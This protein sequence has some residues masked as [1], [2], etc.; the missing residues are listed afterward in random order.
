MVD[1]VWND[2]VFREIA[3]SG[4]MQAALGKAAQA[5]ADGANS[6]AYAHESFAFD[7][8]IHKTPYTSGSKVLSGTAVGYA[9]TAHSFAGILENQF[10]CLSS[11]NH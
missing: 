9:Y 1:I 6:I 11:Q 3:T 8:K 7:K 2:S 10:K 4:E 5:L